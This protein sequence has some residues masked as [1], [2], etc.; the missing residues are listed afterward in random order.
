[1]VLG[2]GETLLSVSA[3]RPKKWSEEICMYKRKVLI[4]AV[5]VCLAVSASNAA[6]IIYVDVNSPN[7]PGIGTFGDPFRKI[8]DGINSALTGD[9]VLIRPGIYSGP[10]NYNLDPVGKAITI[11]STNPEDAEIVANTVIN[12]NKAGR[13]FYIYRSEDANCHISGLTI[14]NA[15][16][17]GLG[18]GITCQNSSPTVSYCV[19]RSN[20]AAWYGGGIFCQDSNAI[21]YNCIVAGNSSL[22]N[23]GGI[24]IWSG[25]PTFKNSIIY[26]N[27]SLYS[28]GGGLDS[29]D[30]AEVQIINCTMAANSAVRGGA[31]FCVASSV[32]VVNSITWA[33][34]AS[35]G[36][37]FGL[38]PEIDRPGI[39]SINFSNISGGQIGVYDPSNGLDWSIGN[40]NSDPCFALF[41]P[42]GDPNLWDF[43]LQSAYGR[44]EPNE[45]NWVTDSNTSLCIDAGD[46]NSDWTGEPWP[47]GKRINMGAYG[48]TAQ[49][50]KNGNIADFDVNGKVDFADFALFVEQWNQESGTIE[51]INRDGVVDV[52]DLDIFTDNWLWEK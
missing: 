19:I 20:S 8:Q 16:T 47:N 48:G 52:L 28:D 31:V 1:M 43:H 3:P 34:V 39:V 21:F 51:D 27:R 32:V 29:Y 40:I 44:W 4:T 2:A 49:A 14:A 46:P 35:S 26:N 38:E 37:E 17:V 42:A 45:Q 18:G 30:G 7:K 41:A 12:P 22:L 15:Y 25:Q 5:F 11:S 36:T 33:N 10:G 24:E 6:N 13:G 9:T 23:G 50:S